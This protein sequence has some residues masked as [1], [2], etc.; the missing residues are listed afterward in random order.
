MPH[1]TL[2]I[3]LKLSSLD[4]TFTSLQMMNLKK[5]DAEDIDVVIQKLLDIRERCHLKAKENIGNAQEKQKQQYDNKHNTLK[6]SAWLLC[7]NIQR[8]T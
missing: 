5:E 2:L 3:W 4:N 8:Y 1:L 6:V 7:Y